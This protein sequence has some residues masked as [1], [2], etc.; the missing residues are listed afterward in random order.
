VPE[1]PSLDEL[2]N[3]YLKELASGTENQEGP[4]SVGFQFRVAKAQEKW[5]RISA[6]IAGASVAVAIAALIVAAIK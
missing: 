2:Y 6:M 4:I 3:A 1:P 5:A